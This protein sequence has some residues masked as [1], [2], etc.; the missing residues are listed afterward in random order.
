[1]FGQ[2]KQQFDSIMQREV[3]RG[4]FLKFMG[5][6]LLG[7]FGVVGFMKN[8]HE[9]VP[10]QTAGKNQRFSGGYGRSPYGR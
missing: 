1:M 6:A 9:I 2:H 8:L 3:N 4:E 7:L 10:A 5:V